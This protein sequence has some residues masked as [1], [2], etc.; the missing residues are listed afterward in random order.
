MSIRD[1]KVSQDTLRKRRKEAKERGG[2]SF[3]RFKEEGQYLVYLAPPCRPDMDDPFVEMLV[4]NVGKGKAYKPVPCLSERNEI[5]RDERVL[6]HIEQ[7][8]D[9]FSDGCPRC[10][11]RDEATSDKAKRDAGFKRQF[12]ANMVVIGRRA[13]SSKKWEKVEEDDLRVQ[14]ANFGPKLWEQ[15]TDVVLDEG[16]IT[17]V[18]HA[19]FLVITRSGKGQNDTEYRCIA[20]RETIRKPA[21]LPDSLVEKLEEALAEGGRGDLFKVI[22]GQVKDRE[23]IED[24]AAGKVEVDDDDDDSDGPLTCYK[25]DYEDDPQC[26]KCPWRGPCSKHL[27]IDLYEGHELKRGDKGF[28]DDAGDAGDEP[29]EKP[30]RSTATRSTTRNP[31][32][33][34]PRGRQADTETR[35]PRKEPEPEEPKPKR[36]AQKP[37]PEESEEPEEPKPKRPAR[38]AQDEKPKEPKPKEPKRPAQAAAEDSETE[39]LRAL[40]YDD[41]QIARMDPKWKKK[42]VLNDIPADAVSV[43]KTGAVAIFAHKLPEDHPMYEAPT[44]SD[45]EEEED[46]PPPETQ[47]RPAAGGKSSARTAERSSRTK[48]PEP[49]ET[50]DE[51]PDE[52]GDD[53]GSS[54]DLGLDDLERELAASARGKG[55]GKG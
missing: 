1:R 48:D 10:D 6:E 37:E 13:D 46:E 55:K 52:A 8:I 21:Q 15:I 42:V 3:L 5:L 36:P 19:V 28:E 47:R 51:L 53:A 25:L 35:R 50:E 45:S 30:R 41:A 32:E 18:D 23:T 9:I 11:A 54:D 4:H 44:A 12:F 24:M 26:G 33:D 39:A 31:G 34:Q 29:E 49:E 17:D 43:L 22:A 2:S 38:P 27:G 20:D 16:D 40:G 14:V 7:G